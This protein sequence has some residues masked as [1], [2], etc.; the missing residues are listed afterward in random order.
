MSTDLRPQRRGRKIAMTA[1]EMDTFLNT[2]RTCRVATVGADGPHVSPL[3]FVWESGALWLYSLNRSL[4][5]KEIAA[6]P[7]VS[8]VIDAGHDYFELRGV[9]IAGTAAVVGEVPRTGEPADELVAVER[10][11]ARKYLGSEELY[12]DG[13]H[14]WLKITPLKVTSWNFRKIGGLS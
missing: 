3:W 14:A 7:R 9:E 10:G 6:D 13:K 8:I 12:Y 5:W 1:D 11:F 4:R 2:E